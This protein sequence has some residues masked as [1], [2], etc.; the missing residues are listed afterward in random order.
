[1]INAGL[2]QTYPEFVCALSLYQL[3]LIEL[4][5][6]RTEFSIF[7]DIFRIAHY[8]RLKA[9]CSTFGSGTIVRILVRRQIFWCKKT[10]EPWTKLSDHSSENDATN[11]TD[12]DDEPIDLKQVHRDNDGSRCSMP[13]DWES[14]RLIKAKAFSIKDILGLDDKEKLRSSEAGERRKAAEDTLAGTGKFAALLCLIKSCHKKKSRSRSG[15]NL[16]SIVSHGWG[17]YRD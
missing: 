15:L 9:N 4:R 17:S 11:D 6:T 7:S 16:M 10:M 5:S 13:S 8:R 14:L 3:L 1:M 2:G 12:I